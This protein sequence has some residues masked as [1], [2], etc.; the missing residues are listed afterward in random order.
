MYLW[1][2]Y[3][4]ERDHVAKNNGGNPNEKFLFHGTGETQPNKVYN[5]QSGFDFRYANEANYYGAG[6]YFSAV[7]KYSH[8]YASREDGADS[9]DDDED[10]LFQFM[11]ARVVCGEVYDYGE[12]T[13]KNTK[14]PP[15]KPVAVPTFETGMR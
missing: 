5:G 12:T 7:P 1:S 9:D 3:S 2:R 10:T 13:A 14:I 11:I 6:A 8:G 15:V 4:N